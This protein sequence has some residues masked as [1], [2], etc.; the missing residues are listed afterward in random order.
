MFDCD[1]LEGALEAYSR[2]MVLLK[3]ETDL[4]LSMSGSRSSIREDRIGIR[5]KSAQLIICIQMA[6]IRLALGEV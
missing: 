1:L 3:G 6:K 5:K 4:A 2:A